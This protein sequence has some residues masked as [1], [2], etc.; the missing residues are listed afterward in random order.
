VAAPHPVHSI[1]VDRS[2][3]ALAGFVIA[4]GCRDRARSISV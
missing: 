3:D 4:I 2:Q 1:A